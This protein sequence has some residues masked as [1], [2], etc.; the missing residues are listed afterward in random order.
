MIIFKILIFHFLIFIKLILIS[1][2]VLATE[3]YSNSIKVL[4]NENIITEY[5]IKQRIKINSIISQIEITKDNYRQFEEIVLQEL[6]NEKLK[7][8]KIKEYEVILTE[9]QFNDYEL[10]YFNNSW[11]DKDSLKSIFVKKNINYELFQNYL[12]I[13]SAWQRLIVGLYLRVISATE[14]EINE[15][16]NKNDFMTDEQANEII[17]QR[18]LDIKSTKL[19]NDLRNEATIEFKK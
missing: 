12:E 2:N 17:L 1:S 3:I 9:K 8:E 13:E 7:E 16:K 15:L 11:M 18:Q 6:I 19:V 10:G 14:T 5:E 4:V